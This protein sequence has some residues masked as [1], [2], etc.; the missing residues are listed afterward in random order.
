MTPLNGDPNLVISYVQPTS[1]KVGIND[2]ELT[3]QYKE[4]MMSFPAKT[5]YTVM[6]EP[7]MPA[8]GH[9]SPNN[10]DPTHV[11]DGHYKGQVNF[12]MTGL[13]KINLTIMDGAEVVDSTSY[14]EVT[15][16]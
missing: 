8:M 11:A 12:T 9:G 13:W 10:V 15:L 16:P 2:F 14:F 4:S 5:D 3:L 1:P 7:E 6:I